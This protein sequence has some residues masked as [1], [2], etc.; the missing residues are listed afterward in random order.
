VTASPG[1]VVAFWDG[2][3][4]RLGV[5]AGEEKQR[6]SVVVEGGRAE[7]IPHARIAFEIER[8]GAPP[9]PGADAREAAGSRAAAARE[10][11]ESLASRIEVPIL[12]DLARETPEAETEAL[13]D[14]ALGSRTGEARAALVTALLR[15]AAHFVRKG[16]RWLPRDSA[17]VEEI[18]GQRRRTSER[19]TLR[20]RALAAIAESA[21][22]GVFTPSGDAEERRFLE[23]LEETAVH[24]PDASESARDAALA[25]VSAAG[26]RFDRSD[27]GAFRLLRR[28]GRFDSDDENL[29][30]LRHRLR[31][32]F[33]EEV[34]AR[35]AAAAARGFDR[36]TRADLTDLPVVTIDDARTLEIDDGL[37]IEPLG[38][39][40]VRVGVHIADPA[41]FVESGDPV[42]REALARGVTHY[43]PDRR[44]PMLPGAISEDAASLLPGADR[45]ALTFLVDVDGTGEV[46]AYDILRSVVRSR[47]R[48]DYDEADRLEG[49]GLAGLLAVAEL[50]E[51]RR[52][53]AGA[54]SIGVP[55]AEPHVDGQGN[56]AVERRD[57]RSPA[58]R[59]VSEMM[60]LA[61]TVAAAFAVDRGFPMIY[62][63]Q[64]AGEPRGD[65][66]SVETDPLVA[67]R[68]ARRGLRRGEIG[69]KA[70]PHAGLGLPAYAQVTSPLRRFQDLAA[71]RQIAAALRGSAPVYDAEALQRI[72]AMTERAD[73]EGRRAERV[74]DR[75]WLL[76]FLEG[77]TGEPVDAVVV[78][79]EPRAVVVLLETMIEEPLR[80]PVRAGVGERIRLRIERVNARADLLRL[81]PE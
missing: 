60:L 15:D 65:A 12:W 73:A 2:G 35:A 55:E 25:A 78:E 49:A 62:R 6:V 24:G 61:G 29:A 27:E 72:A 44:L 17:A 13:A 16:D 69:P 1:A 9:G 43:F 22:T 75:Y 66:P 56:I 45:P 57:P 63:R 19:R 67:A 77:R 33:P 39:G 79:R 11:V 46:V 41:A 7:R 23:A 20:E 10:R 53:A 71:H 14:L 42:D 48:L 8:A 31:T 59:L 30:I 3:D 5:V 70:G 74:A 4:L 52:I 47:R 21:A 76:R 64:A 18:E 37:S 28:L 38:D 68:A 54:I 81:R 34:L 40:L 26:V 51:R 36:E 80:A 50:R 32:E 58:H